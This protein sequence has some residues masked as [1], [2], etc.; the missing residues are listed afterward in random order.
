MPYSGN[1]DKLPL[2]IDAV[3]NPVR[4]NNDFADSWDAVLRNN[5]ANLGKVLQLVSLCDE[6]IAKRFCTLPAVC[7]K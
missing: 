6:A 2:V 1:F 4:S 3:N 7:V 5:S